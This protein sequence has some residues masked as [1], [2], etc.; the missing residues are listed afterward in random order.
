LELA[1]GQLH[2]SLAPNG[3]D[4]TG[5]HGERGHVDSILLREIPR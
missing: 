3:C 1:I 5:G 4:F 2:K